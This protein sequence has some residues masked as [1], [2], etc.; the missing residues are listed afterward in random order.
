MERPILTPDNTSAAVVRELCFFPWDLH[1]AISMI[2]RISPTK[3][4]NILKISAIIGIILSGGTLLVPV[5]EPFP[6]L[7]VPP[8]SSILI[9]IHM[10]ARLT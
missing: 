6:Y 1:L 5:P 9:L 4:I 3:G 10:T 7:S 2:A 8:G